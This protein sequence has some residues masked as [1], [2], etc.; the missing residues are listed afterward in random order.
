MVALRHA[1]HVLVDML[2]QSGVGALPM[3]DPAAPL[4]SVPSEEK[5]LADTTQAIEEQYA[6]Q[7]RI[8]ESAAVVFNLLGSVEQVVRKP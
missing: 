5:L 2:K 3:L 7:Q 8:Q 1:L 6:Q 4:A